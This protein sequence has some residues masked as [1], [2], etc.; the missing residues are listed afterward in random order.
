MGLRKV[1][2]LGLALAKAE[3]K[4]RN[5]G[6]FIGILWYLLNPVLMFVLLLLVFSDRLG[7]NI[8][9][10]PLYILLGIIIFNFFQKVT[11]E[12]T[13]AIYDHRSIIKSIKFPN[14]VLVLSLIFK[15]L[16]AH[17]FEIVIFSVVLIIFNGSLAS[18]LAYPLI[19]ILFLFFCYGVSLF[20]SSATIYLTDMDNIWRFLSMLLWF[21]TPIFYAIEG[22]ERL[23]L[24]NSINPLFYFITAARDMI[25]YGRIPEMWIVGGCIASALASLAIG[26]AAFNMLKKRIPE[27]I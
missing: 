24:F 26:I 12:S 8:P 21:A 17:V 4:L 2:G 19:L 22:Q 10:Y 7:G 6:S 18:M 16:F 14:E 1:L 15:F 23:L 3:F 5:E 9:S 13:K 27:L 20:L 11:V 25:I